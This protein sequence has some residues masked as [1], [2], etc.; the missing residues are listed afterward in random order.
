[1]TAT[2]RKPTVVPAITPSRGVLTE[3]NKSQNLKKLKS[4]APP[5]T[6]PTKATPSSKQS[7]PALS[8]SGEKRKPENV[9][10][11]NRFSFGAVSA[12]KSS[13]KRNDSKTVIYNYEIIWC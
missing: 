4:L 2:S 1:M 13:D 8:S 11:L 12:S 10:D 3:S 5:R 7:K 6:K 9:R